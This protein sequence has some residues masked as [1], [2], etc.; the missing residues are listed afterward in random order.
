MKNLEPMND[1]QRNKVIDALALCLSHGFAV[2]AR[3]ASTGDTISVRPLP[4]DNRWAYEIGDSLDV[5]CGE[6]S[7]VVAKF[8]ANG[9]VFGMVES[10]HV[11]ENRSTKER[12]KD[13]MANIHALIKDDP[14]SPEIS[15]LLELYEKTAHKEIDDLMEER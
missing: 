13:L 2:V 5:I 7:D 9:H 12:L 4:G 8:L 15:R 1:F 14:T 11:R 6:P 10:A 3:P